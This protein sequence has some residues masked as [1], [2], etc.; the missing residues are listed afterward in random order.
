MNKISV[1]LDLKRVNGKIHKALTNSLKKYDLDVTPVQSRIIMFTYEHNEVTAT[2][3]LDK[4]NSINKSTLSEILNNL[5]KN[6]YISRR[7]ALNDSRKKL[8]VLTDKAK[9]VIKVLKKNFDDIAHRV[10]DN[11]SNEE[12]EVFSAILNKI[13]RNVDEI[14]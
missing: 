2:D 11:V 8:I 4:F 10:L 3:I 9:D 1:M 6:G 7:E 14:C 13:E 5:E 12:Y